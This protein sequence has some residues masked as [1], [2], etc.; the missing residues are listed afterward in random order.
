VNN[1]ELFYTFQGLTEDGK[2]HV[3][4]VL[5]ISHPILPADG[6]VIPGGD[7]DAFAADLE[8]YMRDIE[9]QLNGQPSDSFTPHLAPL[10]QMI[11]S[12]QVSGLGE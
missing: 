10:D 7:P 6:S 1:R 8:N 5:P 3:A 9:G 4:A 12:L 11:Q 2:Y